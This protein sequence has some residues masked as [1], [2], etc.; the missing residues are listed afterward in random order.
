ML[1]T[2]D[3]W[4]ESRLWKNF[5]EILWKF[6]HHQLSTMFAWHLSCIN[7][8][9]GNCSWNSRFHCIID[10]ALL[11]KNPKRS[12]KF[13]LPPFWNF[14]IVE[15]KQLAWNSRS[16]HWTFDKALW[17]LCS[18]GMLN[19]QLTSKSW[20]LLRKKPTWCHSQAWLALTP[21]LDY[22]SM[23]FQ[24]CVQPFANFAVY[25]SFRDEAT[26]IHFKVSS[27]TE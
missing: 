21:Q 19:F 22:D 3:F 24:A 11:E 20:P 14:L 4:F 2:F 18:G 10:K 8:K 13:G 23:I 25:G 27:Q 16:F 12:V 7:R 17:K 5:A 26:A 15:R 6:K 9:S 1:H